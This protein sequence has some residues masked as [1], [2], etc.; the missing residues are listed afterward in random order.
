MKGI[1]IILEKIYSKGIL[2]L[3]TT[4]NKIMYL[5]GK[6]SSFDK[7]KFAAS[8]KAIVD[9]ITAIT[10]TG[11]AIFSAIVAVLAIVKGFEYAKAED[12]QRKQQSKEG[13]NG[14]VVAFVLVFAITVL[15]AT[16]KEPLTDWVMTY[17]E[18]MN[19]TPTG[20]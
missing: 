12:Q 10:T 5:T 8:T 6:S 16:M 13:L 20:S 7:D 18:T 17:I 14:L 2:F 4:S 15:M 1:S 9:L 3:T 11:L 19:T